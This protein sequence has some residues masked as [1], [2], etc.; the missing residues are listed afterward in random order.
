M[1]IGPVDLTKKKKNVKLTELCKT[2]ES[3]IFSALVRRVVCCAMYDYYIWPSDIQCFDIIQPR[4]LLIWKT[5]LQHIKQP[6][7]TPFLLLIFYLKVIDA[8]AAAVKTTD[9]CTLLDVDPGS[10]TNRTVY[11]FVGSPEAVVEGALNMAKVAF[12]LI[13]MSKQHGKNLGM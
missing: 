6:R 9:G 1:P 13:D 11:T 8:I 4:W 12:K 2:R 3:L 10:S 7:P 5:I